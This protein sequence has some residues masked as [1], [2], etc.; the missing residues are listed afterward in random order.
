[1]ELVDLLKLAVERKASDVHLKV[2]T[3]PILRIDHKLVPL[4]E[5][6]RMGQD[7]V[8][9]IA[10]GVMNA[11]QR[12]R[13]KEKN[14]ADLAYSVPGLGRFRV[15]VFQQRGLVG[16][17]LR[18]IPLRIQTVGELN[19]PPVLEKLALEPRGL[20]LVTGTTG[21]GKSSTLAAM[22]DHINTNTAGHILTI[23]DPIEFLHRDKKCLVN[24]REVGMDTPGFGEALRSALRQDPDVILVGEMRDFETISTALLAAETGH[25]VMSTLHTL[26]TTETINRIISVFPPYQQKQVRL[27]LASVL[28]GIVSQRLI[29]RA[30]GKGRVPAVEICVATATVREAIVDS[31]KTRKLPDVIAQGFSQ[32]GMQ[33]FDQSLMSLYKRGLITYEE[34]LLWCSNPDDFALK[35]GGIESTGDSNWGATQPEE[36]P[37]T[38]PGMTRL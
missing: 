13:F 10:A 19:L 2:G 23:E 12:E 35:V 36:V 15:N 29:P 28:R 22:I 37:K 24:Q 26:D 27:Q 30:D 31:D 34:A 6:P 32:Y 20:I 14:E 5:L 16:M 25:L 18:L 9:S 3:P 38:L 33:T 4:M 17:V 8:V 1:M 21:S 7:A 11:R